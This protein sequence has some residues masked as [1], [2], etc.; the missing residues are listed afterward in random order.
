MP[1]C[2]AQAL[3]YPLQ[4]LVGKL[5]GILILWL[6]TY[7]NL[8]VDTAAKILKVLLLMKV[9]ALTLILVGGIYWIVIYGFD[10]LDNAFE[11]TKL[12]QSVMNG[13]GLDR[14]PFQE[15]DLA[16]LYS[17]WQ[18]FTTNYALTA[19]SAIV[20]S[21]TWQLRSRYFWSVSG[22]D[23]SSPNHALQPSDMQVTPFPRWHLTNSTCGP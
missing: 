18:V 8:H 21:E 1:Y 4:V 22:N 11:G 3:K 7:I 2:N 20:L 9:L 5:S 15:L 10:N 17:N 19:L 14:M 13:V 12:S 6:V 16:G 23:T